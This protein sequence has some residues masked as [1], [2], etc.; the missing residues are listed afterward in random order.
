MTVLTADQAAS[1]AD[2]GFSVVPRFASDG[3]LT[4]MIDRIVD[5]ARRIDAGE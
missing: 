5:L 2:N 3:V 4:A 1:W